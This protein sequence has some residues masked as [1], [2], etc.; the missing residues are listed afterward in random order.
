MDKQL[1]IFVTRWRPLGKE[2]M[3]QLDY[4]TVKQAHWYVINNCPEVQP[5]LK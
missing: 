4:K 1:N 2:R 5:F 3:V